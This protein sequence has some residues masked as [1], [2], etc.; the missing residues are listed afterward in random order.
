MQQIEQQNE[1]IAQLQ[2][3]IDQMLASMPIRWLKMYE[4]RPVLKK[5]VKESQKRLMIISPWIRANSVNR[6]FL[7]EFEKLLKR[8]V[9]VFIGYGLGEKDE[10]RYPQDIEAEKK[11]QHLA[12]QYA[13]NFTF[14]RLGDTHAKILICDTQFAVI[15]SFNWLS[16][17][18]DPDRTFRD[19]RGTMVCD[20]QKIEELF[21]DLKQRLI[22]A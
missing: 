19:E 3:Q 5:A 1:Q 22:E 11:L 18:G 12:K 7:T 20:S 8:D 14:K 6:G 15:T 4:H 21:D 9:Q 17:K 16:F 13:K 10:P 2:S